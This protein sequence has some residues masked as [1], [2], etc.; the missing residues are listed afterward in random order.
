MLTYIPLNSADDKLMTFFLDF[1]ES[2]LSCF[3]QIVPKGDDLHEMPK[4]ISG[5]DKKNISKCCL[6]KF[7]CSLL[8]VK[9]SLV[10]NFCSAAE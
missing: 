6:Q 8:S 4:P 3:M 5:K 1:P 7:L 2:R 9:S 10:C